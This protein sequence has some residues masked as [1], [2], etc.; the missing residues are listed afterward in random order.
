MTCQNISTHT[1]KKQEQTEAELS[2]QDRFICPTQEVD[3]LRDRDVRRT[4]TY[5]HY[6][7]STSNRFNVFNQKNW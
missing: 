5:H 4:K 2:K 6:S 7:V 3:Y 1:M